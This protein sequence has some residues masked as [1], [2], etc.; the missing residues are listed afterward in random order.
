MLAGLLLKLG[1]WGIFRLRYVMTQ[2]SLSLFEILSIG[3][4]VIGSTIATTQSDGK[5]L[6]AYSSICHMNFLSLL[7]LTACS[8]GKRFRVVIM[9]RH[10]I[11]AA[12]I[13]W[14][15]GMLYHLRGSR[16]LQ[17]LAAA[18]CS[19]SSCLCSIG[20]IL[21]RNLECLLRCHLVTSLYSLVW[22][23]Q[24]SAFS[25]WSCHFTCCLFAISHCTTSCF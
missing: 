18:S 25:F 1:A 23:L 11:I 16:Q 15:T 2:T 22:P 13:F 24:S 10:A 17:F 5:R 8:L 3:G 14:I 4:M 21:F 6:V 7:V 20:F 9:L 19:S 12:M